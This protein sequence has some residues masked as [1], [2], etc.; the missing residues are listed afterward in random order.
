MD[1]HPFPTEA[2]IEAQLKAARP[3]GRREAKVQPRA[4]SA[5]YDEATGR[6]LVEFRNGC[7]VGFP[8]AMV[9][10]L[11]GGTPEQL[12]AV[13]VW[14]DGEALHWEE[15]DAD[16]DLN[17]LMLYAFNVKAWA[18]KYLGSVTSE[19][20]ARASRENGRKGGRPRRKPDAG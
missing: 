3:R 6:V 17:G 19:A 9:Y 13:E 4:A 20:K 7:V 10:G 16:T 11:D 8:V 2:E 18:A 12:A 1:E 5:R 14:E 15:L